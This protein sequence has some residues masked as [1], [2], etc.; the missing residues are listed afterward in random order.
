MYFYSIHRLL[1]RSLIILTLLM[2]NML[3]N[4]YFIYVNFSQKL[5]IPDV[6]VKYWPFVVLNYYY[7]HGAFLCGWQ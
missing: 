3:C 7:N 1:F 2:L 6:S 4:V 5:V